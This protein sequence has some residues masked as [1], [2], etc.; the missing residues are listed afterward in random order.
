MLEDDVP[1]K[2]SYFYTLRNNYPIRRE[3]SSLCIKLD[4]EA[5]S[6]RQILQTLGFHTAEN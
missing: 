4:K 5:E 3:F 1:D 2:N 6:L